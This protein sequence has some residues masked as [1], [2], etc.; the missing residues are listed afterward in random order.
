MGAP[1]ATS[2]QRLLVEDTPD[3]EVYFGSFEQD[4]FDLEECFNASTQPENSSLLANRIAERTGAVTK[5]TPT[6]QQPAKETSFS[7]PKTSTNKALPQPS[8]STPCP[9]LAAAETLQKQSHVSMESVASS[10]NASTPLRFRPYT[11]GVLLPSLTS[12]EIAKKAAEVSTLD[13]AIK[14]KIKSTLATLRK[15]IDTD[16]P[17]YV[18]IHLSLNLTIIPSFHYI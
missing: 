7:T 15:T 1:E 9:S 2:T 8:S 4:S 6:A 14:D 16:S 10:A 12:E 3:K 5:A 11:L 13:I 17:P 18:I